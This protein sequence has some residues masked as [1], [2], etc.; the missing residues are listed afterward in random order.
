MMRADGLIQCIS[1]NVQEVFIGGD[2]GAIH[3][4]LNH[5]LRF[6]YGIKF[7]LGFYKF[8]FFFLVFTILLSIS[9]HLKKTES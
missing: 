9:K 3:V 5:S 6:A 4:E 2:D 7:S 1:Q 8:C